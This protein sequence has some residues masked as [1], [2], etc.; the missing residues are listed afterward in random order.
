MAGLSAGYKLADKNIPLIILEKEDQVGGLAK[1]IQFGEFRFDIGPHCVYLDD[2]KMGDFFY[3]LLGK[4]DTLI[5]KRYSRILLQGKYFDFPLKFTNAVFSMRPN[6][7]VQI[8]GSYLL[9]QIK[10][11]F[12]NDLDSNFEN[13]IINR[14]G[15]AM[16]HLYFKPYTEKVWGIPCSEISKDWADQRIKGLNL[17]ELFKEIFFHTKAQSRAFENKFLYPKRG[18]GVISEKLASYIFQNNKNNQLVTEAEIKRINHNH[19]EIISIEYMFHSQVKKL[20][21]PLCISSI[22][23]TTLVYKLNPSAPSEIITAVRQLQYRDLLLLVL[24]VNKPKITQETWLYFPESAIPFGRITEPKNWSKDLAPPGKTLLLLEYFC[25]END[26]VWQMS[27]QELLDNAINVLTN[28]LKYLNQ[29]DV[30]DYKIVRIKHAYPVYDINYKS[31]VEAVKKYLSTFE[32]LHL[33]GRLGNFQYNH[34][35]HA[36]KDGFAIADKII[37]SYVQ[38]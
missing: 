31:K 32:N 21:T 3:Q 20:L 9:S 29:G 34:M 10:R 19:N 28:K 2:K 30:L 27:G 5:L 35:D 11:I 4:E 26:A 1:T 23:I 37:N 24:V 15:A 6:K 33:V 25:S 22:P 38:Q 8:L 12:R 7:S 13:W 14:F 36:I 18:V 17:K 16:Y